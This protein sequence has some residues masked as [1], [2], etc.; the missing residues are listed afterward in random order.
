MAGLGG[1][2]HHFRLQ[3]NSISLAALGCHDERAIS[4]GEIIL[5]KLN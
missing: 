4:A 2:G 5:L 3:I 1:L